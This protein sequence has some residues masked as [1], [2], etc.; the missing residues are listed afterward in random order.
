MSRDKRYQRLLN[1]P[2]WW[3]VKRVVWQRAGG[4]C[5]ECAKEHYVTPGVDCHHIVP[6]E[7]AKDVA[8][9]EHLC[10]NPDNVRLL[11]IPCHIKAHQDMRSHTTE[12]LKA[13]RQRRQDRWVEAM[14]N[15][16]MHHDTDNQGQE[17]AHVD[18][19]QDRP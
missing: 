16:F 11:C 19:N 1:S 6:V 3:E 17:V 4:L 15:K 9:M 7:T 18:D 10:Y 12:E 5:E 8:T 14:Q 2:R 13:N